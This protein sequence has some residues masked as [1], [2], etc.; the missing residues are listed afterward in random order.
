M[1]VCQFRHDGKWTYIATAAPRPPRQEDQH[2]YSTDT[3]PRVKPRRR[4]S[5]Q[6]FELDKFSVYSRSFNNTET[7]SPSSL[8]IAFLM[9]DLTGNLWLPAPIAMKE[10]W[11]A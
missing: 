1:R 6:G 11:N 5:D 4:T 3:T 10:L 7:E 8:P 9:S 2:L